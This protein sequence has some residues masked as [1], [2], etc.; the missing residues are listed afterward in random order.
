MRC[1]RASLISIF[2]RKPEWNIG[3]GVGKATTQET[4]YGSESKAQAGNSGGRYPRLAPGVAAKGRAI[5]CHLT[6]SRFCQ[7]NA[8]QTYLT[9]IYQMEAGQF[10]RDFVKRGV[11]LVSKACP[12]AMHHWKF[13]GTDLNPNSQ[14]L[15]STR[16]S[17]NHQAQEFMS[18]T[19]GQFCPE[20]L[21]AKCVEAKVCYYMLI[22][23]KLI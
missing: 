9:L 21:S 3:S 5:G 14:F 6:K 11:N 1:V 10:P 20:T 16:Q 17:F 18:V 7:A 19:V 8:G 13:F 2:S 22:G 23:F 15:H 12:L 4:P